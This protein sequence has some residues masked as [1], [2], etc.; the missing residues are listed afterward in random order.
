MEQNENGT[1]ERV[2]GWIIGGKS[3]SGYRLSKG[4]QLGR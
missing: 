3:S 4:L 2:K 1:Q